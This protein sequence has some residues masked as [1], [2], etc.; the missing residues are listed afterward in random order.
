MAESPEQDQ[1]M[2]EVDDALRRERL[3]K[4]WKSYGK[5]IIGLAVSIVAIVAGREIYVSTVNSTQEANSMAYSSA[6]KKAQENNADVSAVWNSTS[7]E[8]GATYSNLAKL[9]L[10]AS[11]A[12]A[13]DYAGAQATY[14][15]VVDD[16]SADSR[17]KDL[18]RY[19]SALISVENNND[20]SAARSELALIAGGE[21]A[22]KVSATEQLAMLDLQDKN[23][24]DARAKLE[25]LKSE[26]TISNE[27]RARVTKLLGFIEVN[28][29]KTTTDPK[30]EGE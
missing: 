28:E 26:Q 30:S 19:L 5:Y 10:A 14:K 7:K 24:T 1:A 2:Q 27:M 15:S 17:I 29:P 20:K 8:M 23:F 11:Q 18:A 22:Y 16:S 21:G 6:L 3:E 13:K 12:K 4:I 25:S 9:H